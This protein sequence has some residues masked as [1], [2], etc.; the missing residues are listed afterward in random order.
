MRRCEA[1]Q[2]GPQKQTLLQCYC[3]LPPLEL[4]LMLV[5][6]HREVRLDPQEELPEPTWI[7]MTSAAVSAGSASMLDNM[8]MT[9][10]GTSM[11]HCWN[12]CRVSKAWKDAETPSETM[13]SLETTLP[14]QS[15]SASP[16][17][18]SNPV[19]MMKTRQKTTTM[20]T[21]SVGR[22]YRHRCCCC[23]SLGRGRLRRFRPHHRRHDA[24]LRS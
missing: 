13:P 22:M 24:V 23:C 21:T 9:T 17:T 1:R 2:V 18:E 4:M 8:L 14:L 15:S 16:T 20:T 7:T 12:C 5:P 19:M 10:R 11:H 3:M 6:F